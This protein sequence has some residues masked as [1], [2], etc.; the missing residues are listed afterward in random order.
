M[1]DPSARRPRRNPWRGAIVF[2]IVCVSWAGAGYVTAH[3]CRSAVTKTAPPP[4]PGLAVQQRWDYRFMVYGVVVSEKAD[5]TED[6]LVA[7][8]DW[9]GI[10]TFAAAASVGGA[11]AVV[12]GTLANSWLRCRGER[13]ATE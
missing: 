12:V 4:P 13:P 1:P 10:V 7:A 5:V 6:E 2:W 11:Y 3:G 8:L 9:W